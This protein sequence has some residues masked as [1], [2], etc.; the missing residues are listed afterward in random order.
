M[1]MIALM[2]MHVAARAVGSA[3]PT[4]ATYY[5]KAVQAYVAAGIPIHAMTL[6]AVPTALLPPWPEPPVARMRW[7]QEKL[8][9]VQ[10]G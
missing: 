5:R 8:S 9:L 10:R 7:S 1:R 3:I 2:V 6:P 4:L